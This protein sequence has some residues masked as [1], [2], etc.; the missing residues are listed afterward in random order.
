MNIYPQNDDVYWPEDEGVIG[1]V[2][3]APWATL[4]FCKKV[5]ELSPAKKDWHYP[6][7][8]VDANSKIPS[9]GRHL[10]LGEAD[11]S[12]YIHST[13]DAL[14]DNGATVAVVPCNTAHILYPRWA[15]NTA[16]PVIGSVDATIS[17]LPDQRSTKVAIL[18]SLYLADSGLYQ[19]G[20]IAAG[21]TLIS[22]SK[23]QQSVVSDSIAHLKQQP[24]LDQQ[25]ALAFSSLIDSLKQAG[26]EVVILACTELSLLNLSPVW[27]GL[28]VIDSNVELARVSLRA[29]GI[30]AL[31]EAT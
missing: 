29:I 11:P 10:E 21:H 19:Q 12:P 26:T 17:A 7:I 14:A 15:Q 23:A 3:V 27:D 13:I 9:R 6:R 8:I 4:D 28:T 22:L 2:G 25:R 1:V 24:C 31:L 20:I 18:S 30:N 5:Y 16:V